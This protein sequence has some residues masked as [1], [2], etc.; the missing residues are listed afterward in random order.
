M[1]GR[2]SK[3]ERYDRCKDALRRARANGNRQEEKAALEYWIGV[4]KQFYDVDQLTNWLDFLFTEI[5]FDPDSRDLLREPYKE[6]GKLSFSEPED[7]PVTKLKF[8]GR[9]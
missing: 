6:T 8:K 5:E 9:D 2:S 1:A 7:R 4:A 3:K